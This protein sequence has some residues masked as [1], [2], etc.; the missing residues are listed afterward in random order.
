[1]PLANIHQGCSRA[2]HCGLETIKSAPLSGI[3]IVA[4]MAT[5]VQFILEFLQRFV[6]LPCNVHR[7]C[8]H[9]S[10]FVSFSRE[11]NY[12]FLCILAITILSVRLSVTRV[13]QPKTVQARITKSL[14]SAAWKTLVVSGSEKLFRKFEGGQPERGR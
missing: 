9:L 14:P 11:S 1:M 10:A 8:F 4:L 5:I 3:I 12:C 13:D 7:H 6:F 2:M